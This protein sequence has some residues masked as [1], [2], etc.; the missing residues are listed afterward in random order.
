MKPETKELTNRIAGERDASTPISDSDAPAPAEARVSAEKRRRG[1]IRLRLASLVIA[2]VLPVWVVAGSLIYYS[3]QSKRAITERRMM[4]TARALTAIVDRE[5]ENMQASLSALATS[6]SLASGDLHAFYRQAQVVLEAHPDDDIIVSDATSQELVHTF[7][8]FGVS[9]PKRAVPQTVHQVYETGKPVI[10]GVYRGAGTGRLQIAVDVPVFRGGRVVYDLAMIAFAGRLATVLSE[11]RLPPEWV[12]RILDGNQIVVARTRLAERFVGQP[13]T[14]AMQLRIGD[15][16]EGMAETPNLEGI[17]MFNSFNRSVM[18][19]WTVII[20]V[21]RAI[22]MAELWQWLWWTLA[23]TA[24]LSLTG[25][26]LAL[27]IGRSVEQIE[28]GSRR[29]SEIVE[30]SD[31]A[32]ISYRFDGII[33]S[34]NRGAEQLFGYSATDIV[35]R[36]ISILVP[37]DQMN[38]YADRLQ[39]LRN[40]GVIEQHKTTRKHK[41]GS[42]L[43]VSLKISPTFDRQGAIVGASAIV[44][45]ITNL[46][47]AE[48]ALSESEERFR[49][50]YEQAAVGIQQL[51]N[52][53]RLLMVNKAL[54]RMLGYSESELIGR[55]VI[56]LTHPD[57]LARNAL[58]REPMLRGERDSYEAEKR[59]LH[60]DGSS[61]WVHVTSSVVRGASGHPLYRIAIVQDIN[62]RKQAEQ[63][64][65]ATANRLKAVLDNAPIGVDIVDRDGRVVESNAEFRRITGFS[66]DE[67]LGMNFKDITH[68]EDLQRNLE[69]FDGLTLGATQTYTL[70]KRYIRKD[71][72]SIWVRLIGS[73]LSDEQRIGIVE[74][75]TERRRAEQAFAESEE[76]LRTI[77]EL[78]PDGIFVVSDLGEIIEVNQAACK[79]LG[80][81]RG[82]LLQLKIFDFISPRFAQRVAARLRGDVPSGSYES[83][84]VRADGVEVPVELSVTKI[85]FG[86]QPAFL[87]ITRDTSDRKRAEEQ[88]A[89]LEKELR[90]AQKME[91]VGRLAGGIAHDFNNLLMI[92]QSYT[93]MLQD[94]LP[95]DDTLQKNTQEIMAAANRAASLTRQMLAYSRKQILSPVVLELNVVIDETAKMLRR[96]IGEDIELR[97]SAAESL[98][99][100]EADSDQIVQVLMNLCVNAR[101]AMPRGGTLTVAT[102]NVTV[103]EG[104]IGGQPPGVVPGDYVRLSVA[105]TGTGISKEMQG[106]IFDPFFTTKE[107]GKGTGLG[108]AMVYGIVKQSGGHVW[109]DSELG[110]GTCFTIYLPRTKRAIV[111]EMPAKTEAQPRG[112]GTILVAEDEEALRVAMCGY[113]RSLG[114][115]VLE[116]SS[117]K[118]A[119]SIASQEGHIDLLIT[120]LVMPGMNGRELSQLLGSLRLDLRTICMSGYSDDPV[121]R[122]DINE[123]GAAFLQKPFSLG[124]LARKVRGTLRPD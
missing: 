101:D 27:P 84:H 82:Q 104:S 123:L 20:G 33:E 68:P 25:I 73:E 1:S 53:G 34:W 9:L 94:S 43:P 98:W 105:D 77:V 87:G 110:R 74:D 61:V 122:H 90:H 83:A 32:I 57:D 69:L 111:P 65:K 108:L 97:V 106:R 118:Q 75:I 12:G 92:I 78:A 40:G 76:R 89:M 21:P 71:G 3:Y 88:R 4:D 10:T 79:Q 86:G 60:R 46:E 17:L 45:D 35:G 42:P 114:Y 41:N 37:D 2:C 44:R 5:L 39:S 29:L 47:N 116:A 18:S 8:P 80:Y 117:G 16:A 124:T 81:T 121:S 6:P 52:D 109:V 100:I 26:A 51:A 59:Y 30:S 95:A 58:L 119:L 85:M 15:S 91:A 112:T 50:M 31:D 13:A 107:V 23:G 54:C 49:S 62:T 99:A 38:D 55:D 14:P 103:K 63:E 120:D 22:M 28:S 113:L 36:Q 7:L 11:Q 24:L 70:E 115:T 48:E 56:G 102:G 96:L 72:E 19:G 93:E 66:G 64:L 67:L